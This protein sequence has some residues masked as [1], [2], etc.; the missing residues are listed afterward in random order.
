MSKK[1]IQ[2]SRSMKTGFSTL[3]ISCFFCFTS[4]INVSA[5]RKIWSVDE[6]IQYA[7]Q[8]N[9]QVKQAQV[10]NDIYGLDMNYAKSAWYP[11]LSGSVRQNFSWSNQTNNTTGSTVFKGTD[12]TNISLNSGMTV[13]NGNRIRNNVKQSEINY[14]AARYNTEVI[15]ETVSLN[16]LNAYLQVLFAEEQVKNTSD[17]IASLTEQLNLAG[18]RLRLGV[19]A[20]SDYLQVKSQLATEKQTLATARSQLAINRITLMQLMEYAEPGAGDFSIEHPNLDSLVNQKRIPDPKEVYQTALRVKPEVKNAELNK[21][22]SQIGIELAKSGL[23]PSLSMNAGL[24]TLYSS[25]TISGSSFGY[26]MKNNISPAI[27]VTAS[28]PIYLNKQARTNVAV[29]RKSNENAELN[30]YNVKN[31]LRKVIEQACQDVISSQIEY[32]ASVEAYNAV[33]E[34]YDV[35]SEKYNQGIMNSVDFLI[36]KTTYI[37]TQSSLLQSKYRLVFSYKVLDFYAGLP[38]SFS[39]NIK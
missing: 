13:Y 35:A 5:Q 4:G 32:E 2:K 8:K 3:L 15:K 23:Y 6:C 38:L 25:N 10:S 20:N 18:E 1:M 37:T 7:L 36:Q 21:Q 19:I 11:S 29:A 34:S 28:I 27:G 12:G 31:Q 39:S 24:S 9:I 14:E 17:Q 26:Q 33:K 22:S 30:E 16:V